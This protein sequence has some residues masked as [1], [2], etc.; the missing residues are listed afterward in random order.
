MSLR[1]AAYVDG[2]NLYFGLKSAGFRRYYW[3]DVSA[4]A[5]NLMKPGQVLVATHYFS[6]RRRS[7]GVNAEELKRQNAYLE[8]LAELGVTCQFGHFLKKTKTCQVC[9]A[10]WAEY[11]EK[12]TDVNIA[13][14]LTL[15]AFDDL[16]DVA[17][18]VSGDSDLC[19]PIETLKA[20]FPNKRFVV[21][22]P[23]NRRSFDLTRVADGHVY[24]GEDTLRA[25][26]L[27]EV[28]T[29]A[30]GHILRRPERWA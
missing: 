10:S 11:E 8:A 17:M 15:D 23:P 9:Q 24:V 1:V 28:V 12:K 14:Q 26:Q 5:Q 7:T 29:K 21:A 19:P 16:Y 27:P 25:S 18:V 6:A 4:L 22:L 2:F 13:L 20:R 3:L 30:N